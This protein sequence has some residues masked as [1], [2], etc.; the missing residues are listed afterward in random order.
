MVTQAR[1]FLPSTGRHRCLNRVRLRVI[2]NGDIKV[3]SDGFRALHR[4]QSVLGAADDQSG[5]GDVRGC[6]VLTA[7]EHLGGQGTFREWPQNGD[8]PPLGD[9]LFCDRHIADRAK[10]HALNFTGAKIVGVFNIA[11]E[12]ARTET[13]EGWGHVLALEL[14]MTA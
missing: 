9:E 7:S 13:F 14:I 8:V 12:G 5:H 4:Y 10:D 6:F 11:G 1:P 3:L 2:N